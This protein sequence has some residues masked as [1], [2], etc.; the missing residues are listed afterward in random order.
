MEEMAR[1]KALPAASEILQV[2]ETEVAKATSA[3]DSFTKRIEGDT[4][5]TLMLDP[6]S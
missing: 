5:F 3:L 4:S 2:L 1:Q 6:R